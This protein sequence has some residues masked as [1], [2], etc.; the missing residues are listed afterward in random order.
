[1]SGTPPN[2]RPPTLIVDICIVRLDA[3]EETWQI[4]AQPGADLTDEQWSRPTRCPGWDVAAVYAHTS[5][6][7][8]VLS[9]SPPTPPADAAD[10]VTAAEVLRRFN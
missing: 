8:Q 10:V 7:P 3:L 4:W 6:F 5:V 1:M 2:A 9:A